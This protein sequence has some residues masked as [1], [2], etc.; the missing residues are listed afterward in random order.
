MC[1]KL[2]LLLMSLVSQF[3]VLSVICNL[4]HLCHINV[5]YAVNVGGNLIRLIL[6]DLGVMQ[7]KTARYT[8]FLCLTINIAVEKATCLLLTNKIIGLVLN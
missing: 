8:N 1:L 6:H 5:I 7:L 3:N 2:L 4:F